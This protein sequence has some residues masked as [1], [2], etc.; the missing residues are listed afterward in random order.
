MEDV[1][2]K[3]NILHHIMK[4]IGE[5]SNPLKLQTLTN[6]MKHAMKCPFMY[7][8]DEIPEKVVIEAIDKLV[9]TPDS[10]KDKS[11]YYLQILDGVFDNRL[12]DVYCRRMENEEPEYDSDDDDDST[13]SDYSTDD[14]DDDSMNKIVEFIGSDTSDEEEKEELPDGTEPS[15]E[16]DEKRKDDIDKSDKTKVDKETDKDEDDGNQDDGN[17]DNEK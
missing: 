17:Q 16:D 3:D 1:T 7:I 12:V 5:K 2:K 11:N 14:D 6:V 15:H 9:N 13:D 10:K 4:T 8:E